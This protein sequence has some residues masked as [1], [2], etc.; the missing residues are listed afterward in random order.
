MILEQGSSLGNIINV[1]PST[2]AALLAGWKR[3]TVLSP[4]SGDPATSL[5]FH[6]VTGDLPPGFGER[7]PRNAA[8]LDDALINVIELWITAGAPMDDWVPGTDQ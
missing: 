7:M 5:L 2:E 8:P 6:K 1:D 4:T 3:V